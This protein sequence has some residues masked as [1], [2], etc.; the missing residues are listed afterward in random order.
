MERGGEVDVGYTR[1]C[2]ER[3]ETAAEIAKLLDRVRDLLPVLNKPMLQTT[4]TATHQREQRVREAAK[5]YGQHQ[6]SG[7][8]T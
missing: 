8:P 6:K 3:A 1:D 5:N 4:T 7:D 2:L